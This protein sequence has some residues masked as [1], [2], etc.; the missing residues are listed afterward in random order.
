MNKAGHRNCSKKYKQR[1]TTTIPDTGRFVVDPVPVTGLNVSV[2]DGRV[3]GSTVTI[4]TRTGDTVTAME[5]DLSTGKVL[6]VRTGPGPGH[7]L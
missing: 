1:A 5:S 7:L 3:T 4:G 6:V 2:S